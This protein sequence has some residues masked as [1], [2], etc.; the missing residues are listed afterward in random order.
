M[1]ALT[2]ACASCL[3]VCCDSRERIALERGTSLRVDKQLAEG[4]F[5]Y[6]FIAVDEA[7]GQVFS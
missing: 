3:R 5:S 6:V 2:E 4:G 1:E 7:T